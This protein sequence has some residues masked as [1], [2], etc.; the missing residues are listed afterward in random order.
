MAAD[1]RL[2]IGHSNVQYIFQITLGIQIR[3]IKKGPQRFEGR[4]PAVPCWVLTQCVRQDWDIWAQNGN[5]VLP[6]GALERCKAGL[7]DIQVLEGLGGPQRFEGRGPAVPCWVLTQCVRQA[8][9]NGALY[10][11]SVLPMGALDRCTSG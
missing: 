1:W 4:G 2:D 8:G 9:D 10:V 11:T 6:M 7:V 3:I 5:I